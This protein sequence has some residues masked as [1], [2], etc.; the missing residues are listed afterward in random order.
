MIEQNVVTKENMIKIIS[1]RTNQTIS[2]TRDFYNALEDVIFDTLCS[3]NEEQ[4]VRIKLFEGI[5]LDGTYL[6]EKMK[7]N[8]LTGKTSLVLGRIKPKFNITRP[9]IEKINNK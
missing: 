3:T 7:T 8:N 6:P 4:N 9:Y 1:K 2:D 5:S